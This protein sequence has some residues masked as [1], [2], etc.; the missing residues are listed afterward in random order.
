MDD[1][2]LT[3]KQ[4]QFCIEYIVDSNATQAAIRA[5]YPKRG[6]QQQGSRL[7]L[8]DVARERIN[9]LREAKGEVYKGD[10]DEAKAILWKQALHGKTERDKTAAIT[11]LS[12][13]EP[14]WLPK[15]TVSTDYKAELTY[16]PHP[17]ISQMCKA[18]VHTYQE[19]EGLSDQAVQEDDDL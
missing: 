8:N 15:E 13:M 9:E 7:L 12:R 14:G 17:T 1:P 4:Q 18:C 11:Q 16:C 3:D 5:G 10:L 6:A 19:I 2:K